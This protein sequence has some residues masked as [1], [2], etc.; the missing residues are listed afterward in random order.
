MGMTTQ[1]VSC[2]R[3][4][5]NMSA[6]DVIRETRNL[7]FER[8]WTQYGSVDPDGSMCVLGALTTVARTADRSSVEAATAAVFEAVGR[9]CTS[10]TSWNDE[11]G[12]TFSEVVEMLERAERVADA[13]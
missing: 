12:R 11:S 2:Y 9:G 13:S 3:K 4:D 10:V 5:E 1:I 8:G 6:S 7:L